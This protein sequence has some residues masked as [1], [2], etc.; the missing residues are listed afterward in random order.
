[1][2][3]VSN[4]LV[5]SACCMLFGYICLSWPYHSKWEVSLSYFSGSQRGQVSFP[6]SLSW[7]G[8]KLGLEPSL[9]GHVVRKVIS[10]YSSAL[11]C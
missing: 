10:D 3:G 2:L 9:P 6:R 5:L 7:E 4:F 8:T 11:S 1:M